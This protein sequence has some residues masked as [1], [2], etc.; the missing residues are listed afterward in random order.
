[1]LDCHF[2]HPSIYLF[3]IRYREKMRELGN[4]S[5]RSAKAANNESP[6]VLFAHNHTHTHRTRF[7]RVGWGERGEVGWVSHGGKGAGEF[8][9]VIARRGRAAIAITP[10]RRSYQRAGLL[11]SAT[12]TYVP[13][14]PTY[15]R[16]YSSTPPTPFRPTDSYF[17]AT[18]R[19]SPFERLHGKRDR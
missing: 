7:G 3:R 8:V 5:F 1:M 18:W 15:L 12:R 19:H 10:R 17:R 16:S 13:Y 9:I 11:A 6:L 14:L 4:L 2:N